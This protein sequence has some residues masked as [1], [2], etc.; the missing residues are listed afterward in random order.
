MRL[1]DVWSFCWRAAIALMIL[2]TGGLASFLFGL[3]AQ[4]FA[5]LLVPASLA[6]LAYALARTIWF[7]RREQLLVAVMAAGVGTVI[8]AFAWSASPPGH[9]LVAWELN[10]IDLPAGARLVD[11][12]ES[13]NV[14]CFDTCPSLARTYRVEGAPNDVV[15]QMGEALRGSGLRAA[16]SDPGRVSFSSDPDSHIQVTV[17]IGPAYR[18]PSTEA[19]PDPEPIAGMSEITITARARERM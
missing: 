11:D 1:M 4:P 13:G 9:R 17:A 16:M 2:L 15:I 19:H 14:W 12:Q 3:G 5:W 7:D 8:G 6:A 18:H 10:G